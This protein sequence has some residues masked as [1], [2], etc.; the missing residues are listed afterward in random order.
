MSL[1]S[2]Q[3]DKRKPIKRLMT[4]SEF[5]KPLVFAIKHFVV[6]TY[7]WKTFFFFSLPVPAPGLKPLTLAI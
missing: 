2:F 5:Y 4:L 3:I 6:V 7:S 1:F